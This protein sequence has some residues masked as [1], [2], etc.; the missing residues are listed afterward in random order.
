[1]TSEEINASPIKMKVTKLESQNQLQR[2][3]K[4]ETKS[5]FSDK[6]LDILGARELFIKRGDNLSLVDASV[7]KDCM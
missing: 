3:K 5:E 6:Y 4:S 7:K 1:M 2:N